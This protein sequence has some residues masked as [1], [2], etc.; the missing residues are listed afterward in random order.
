MLGS[1]R[2]L[3]SDGGKGDELCWRSLAGT[4]T[5]GQVKCTLLKIWLHKIVQKKQMPGIDSYTI[6]I[7]ACLLVIASYLFNVLSQKQEYQQ[8]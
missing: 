7:S 6:I 1:V 3:T 4:L 5:V 8:Y 2:N